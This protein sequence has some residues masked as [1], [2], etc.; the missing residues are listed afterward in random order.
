MFF[1][2]R[3]ICLWLMVL[4]EVFVSRK[5]WG[6]ENCILFIPEV[7]Y[8]HTPFLSSRSNLWVHHKNRKLHGKIGP[9]KIDRSY[10]PLVMVSGFSYLLGQRFR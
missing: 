9:L 6:S 10:I 4:R 5:I 2:N 3:Q 7:W 1:L 8:H